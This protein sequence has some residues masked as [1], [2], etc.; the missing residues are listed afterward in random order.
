MI[1]L[2]KKIALLLSFIF[3]FTLAIP[4]QGFAADIDKT[5]EN[6][7]KIAKAK[8]S[9]PES[10]KFNSNISTE[11]A[12]KIFY[13]SWSSADTVDSTNINVRIDENGAIIGYNKY[14]P[15]DY[16]QARK[17]PKLSRQD[18]KAKA[19]GYIKWIEPGLL[20]NL[21]YEESTQASIM[22]TSYY[23]SYYRVV[24]GIPFYNDRVTVNVN[25]K[26]GALQDYSR[27]WTDNQAFPAA[28]N[29]IL[30]KNAEEA[31]S[32]N[33]GLR[34]IYKYTNTNDVLKTYAVYV[35]IYDNGNY[36]VDAF[37]GERQRLFNNYYYGGY[38]DNIMFTSSQKS[39]RA[40]TDEEVKL[41]PDELK[42]VQD[43]SKLMSQED[44]EKKIARNSKFLN[45]ST[46]SKLQSYFLGTNWPSK[47]EYTWFLQFNKPAGHSSRYD[48]YTSVA[49]D[50][51]TGVITSFYRG[52]PYSEETKPKDDMA[53]AKAAVD[54]FLAENYPQYYKQVEY[55]KL[56]SESNNNDNGAKNANYNFVYSR[57]ANGIA[58]P[59]NGININYDNV[60]GMIIGF[61]L[62]WFN[63]SFASVDKAIGV[64]A[65]SEKLY[66][67]VGLGL[68]YKYEYVANSDAK[69]GVSPTT[70]AKVLLIYSLK[71]NKPLL[72][73]A[74]TGSLLTYDG[75]AFKEAAK[76]NYTDI[77][78]NAAEKQIMVL[79]EN[80][81]YLEGTE[82][83]PNATITQKDFL[84]LLSRTLSYYGPIITLK[85]S[86]KDVDELYAYLQREGIVK[87]GEKAPGNAVTKEE[88]VKFIIRALKFDKVADIKGIYNSKY[89][90]RAS[91][92]QNL[93]G[94]VTIAAGLGIADGKSAYFKP[95]TKLTRGESAIMIYNYLQS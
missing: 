59:D 61:N 73:D 15:T 36:G 49:I 77:K 92:N 79:A 17:L 19:D 31:Y 72:V 95:K 34:L 68:E 62:N 16:I 38:N 21:K 69:Y 30:L 41:N 80:G 40:A 26:T 1:I 27:Q 54:V 78:G 39:A 64:A 53:T 90:D 82:F 3:I 18:A 56:T 11:G 67:N 28:M 42:A 93:I 35:P 51:K 75:T 83:K 76:V 94:Y 37:T 20:E 7:I 55:D 33:L 71:P 5:L 57:L 58:F 81:I 23:L 10:Y 88:A 6:V 12:K 85:S 65:A 8:F 74:N 89:K 22:D 84:T 70:N 14:S 86:S 60:S 63:I 52:A 46:D 47:E 48:E 4:V 91:I 45:I 2:K 44:A 13:L 50:A 32:K 25:R 24:N 9:V 29:P 66:K 87:A 43:A